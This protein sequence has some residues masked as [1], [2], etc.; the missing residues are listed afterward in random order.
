MV[1]YY[2]PKSHIAES[3]RTL[4][5]NI[6]FSSI[7]QSIQCILITSAQPEDGKSTTAANLAI[8]YAQEN[9]NVLLIDADLRKPT[10]H[11]IFGVSNMEGLTHLLI[12]N[13]K[14]NSEGLTQTSIPNLTLLPSGPVPPNPAE[15]LSSNK[16]STLINEM[17]QN[18]DIIIVDSPPILAVTDSQVLASKVDGVVLVLNHGKVKKDRAQKAI[19]QLEYVKAKILGVVLNNKAQSKQETSY[20]YY[21]QK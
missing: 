14:G 9:K 19:S 16:M 6:Q 13:L 2:N 10:L 5:T 3:Y 21:Q 8:A 15:L 17:R 18:F 11:K 7:D 20:Y 1:T 4:R 12:N